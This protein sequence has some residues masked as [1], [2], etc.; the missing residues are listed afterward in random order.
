ML[1][2]TLLTQK[3]GNLQNG[4]FFTNG[5][6]LSFLPPAVPLTFSFFKKLETSV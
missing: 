2:S 6:L 1:F 5:L 4:L 3:A